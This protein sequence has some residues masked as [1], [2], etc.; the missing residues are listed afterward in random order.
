[1]YPKLL[2][3]S[4]SQYPVPQ[5]CIHASPTLVLW[6]FF[7]FLVHPTFPLDSDIFQM[8]LPSLG[9]LP[10]THCALKALPLTPTIQALSDLPKQDNPFAICSPLF[11]VTVFICSTGFPSIF[12]GD[13]KVEGSNK[14]SV[15]SIAGTQ[16]FVEWIGTCDRCPSVESQETFLNPMTVHAHLTG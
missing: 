12:L 1:M 13:K 9:A 3:K 10:D 16:I 5:L 15:W 4:Q 11:S 6:V 7:P 2:L 14:F 8:L